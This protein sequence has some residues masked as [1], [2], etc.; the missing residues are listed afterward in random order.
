VKTTRYAIK[1]LAIIAAASCMLI[2]SASLLPA[3]TPAM[4]TPAAT[5]APAPVAAKSTLSIRIT[6]F[7]SAKGKIN[8]ALFR[9]GKGFPSDPA[10]STASQRLE[11]DPQTKTATAVFTNLPQG[12]YA[13][14][15][16]HDENLT[17]KMEYDSQG[18]PQE[19][20]GISNNPD[21]TQGPPTADG[22]KFTVSQ[23]QTTI[24]IKLVYW[25]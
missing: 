1:H 18:V 8:I 4:P 3:Q 2:A 16:F 10:S 21:T 7:R 20:Y 14:A 25:Q 13:A 9:D 22:A 19:G 15:V 12:S 24:E 23:P 5:S 11:I 17:G 6:G